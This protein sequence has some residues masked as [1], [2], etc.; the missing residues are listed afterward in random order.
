[1]PRAAPL[2]MWP[3]AVAGRPRGTAPW[4]VVGAV[5]RL[6]MS[7]VMLLGM[8]S[9][10]PQSALRR[11]GGG[12]SDVCQCHGGLP[13]AAVGQ[14]PRTSPFSMGGLEVLRNHPPAALRAE[15]DALQSTCK[16]L[17]CRLLPKI[18][19][20]EATA[21]VEASEMEVELLGAWPHGLGHASLR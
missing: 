13:P 21:P 2:E 1:M 11:D 9:S 17:G 3:D 16:G 4:L 5:G 7:T 6:Q 14:D 12:L 15:V 10:R 8:D 20:I 18:L 19:S